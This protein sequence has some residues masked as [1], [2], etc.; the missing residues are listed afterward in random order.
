MDKSKQVRRKVVLNITNANLH[1]P[2]TLQEYGR[3]PFLLYY[4]RQPLVV[5]R[6]VR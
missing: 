6:D 5:N 1:V 2:T 3:P 4:S